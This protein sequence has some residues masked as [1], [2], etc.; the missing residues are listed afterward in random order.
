MKNFKKLLGLCLILISTALL[1]QVNASTS[2][3][4]IDPNKSNTFEF[5]SRSANYVY[6]QINQFFET[7]CSP[8]DSTILLTAI[9][10]NQ[11][12]FS[13]TDNNNTTWEYFVQ[14][15]TGNMPIGSG[16]LINQKTVTITGLTGIVGSTLAPNTTYEFYLRANC[17]Q[18]EKSNW[19]GPIR[20]TTL[21]NE[22]VL[23]FWEG[24]N[25]NSTSL[26]CWTIID[27]NND[28]TSPTGSNIF[29]TVASAY[30]SDQSMYFNGSKKD[31][32]DDWLITPT[33]SIQS[34]KYYKLRYHYKTSSSYK[35]SFK[36]LLSQ[37][38][39]DVQSFVQTLQN[40]PTE[41]DGDWQQETV[42]ISGITAS[43]NIAWHVNT[44]D[45]A[46]NLYIDNVFFEEIP[47]PQP[48]NLASTSPT[49]NG[50]TITWEDPYATQWEFI[51]QN[52]LAGA[53]ATTATGT[54]TTTTSNAITT[55]I[56]G[57]T[58]SSDTE[59]EYYVRSQCSA[60]TYGEWSGPY[61]FRTACDTFNTPFW[62]GFNTESTSINC[63]TMVDVNNDATSPTGNNLWKANTTRYE[64]SHSMM[65]YGMANYKH[66]DWLISPT[67]NLDPTKTYRLK[68]NYRT[69][70]TTTYDFEFAV[71]LSTNGIASDQFNTI[72]VPTQ[73]YAPSVNW[74][75]AYTFISGIGGQIN[76][77][78]HVTSDGGTYI[79]IDNVYVEEV[80]G[81][82]EPIN[83]GAKDEKTDR[84]TIYWDNDNATKWEYYL[85][86]LGAGLP[87]TAGTSTTQ[88]EV[89][90]TTIATGQNLL[91][92]TT[93]EFYVRTDCGNGDSSIWSGPFVFTTACASYTVPFW[94]GFNTNS[95]T[96][97]CWTIIDANAD[98][99]SPT[100]N[101]IWRPY[102]N[103]IPTGV[104]EG[105]QSM[106]FNG[107]ATTTP[108]D[109]W[110]IS[111]ILTLDPGNY[112]L[113]YH[114]RT[115]A[116]F[117]NDFEVLLSENGPDITQFNDTILPLKSYKN[118]NFV[119]EI[120]L[121]NVG[122][123]KE[124]NIAWHA[125][126]KGSTYIY[127]D[128]IAL[129]K[130][131]N[132]LEP[133][134]ITISN[135][136]AT[137]FDISWL[138][139]DNTTEWEVI[140][141]QYG[142]DQNGTII[143]QQTVSNTPSTTINGLPS[144]Q[145]YTVMV[146]AVCKNNNG[147][148]NYSTSANLVT[149]IGNNNDCDGAINLPVN[150]S[151]SCEQIVSSSFYGATNST[152]DEPA[153]SCQPHTLPKKDVWFKFTALSEI[154]LLSITDII[155]FSGQSTPTIYA[156]LYDAQ[157]CIALTPTSSLLCFQF[158]SSIREKLFTNLIVGQQYYLRLAITTTN[159]DAIFNLC[160]TSSE[161]G[162]IEVSP[163]GQKY[164]VDEL[165]KN[166]LISSQC[167]LVSNVKFQ[168][169]DGQNTVNAF[170]YFN[171]QNADFPFEEGI[172]LATGD[173]KHIPGPHIY[174]GLNDNRSKIPVWTG[175]PDLNKII[176]DLGGKSFG[177]NKSVSVLEFD[178]IPINDSISFEYLF[179]SQSYHKDCISYA[180]T[181]GGA[182]FAAW[183]IDLETGEGQNLALL[184]GT[185][186][187]IAL[188][189]IRDTDKSGAACESRN[190]EYYG[191]HYTNGVNS[192]LDAPFNF[193][194]STI[195]MTS[196]KVS[197]NSCKKYKIKLAIADFCPSVG[198]TSAVF[199]NAGS[200]NLGNINLGEDLLIENN[201]AMCPGSTTLLNSKL[202]TGCAD[203]AVINWFKDGA[204][205]QGQNQSTLE[206]NSAGD[207]KV[208][209]ELPDLNCSSIGTIKVEMYPNLKDIIQPAN[210]IYVCRNNLNSYELD[211]SETLNSMFLK[212]KRAK[213]N[214]R[215][216]ETDE[217]AQTE[218]NEI[219]FTD[220]I[221]YKVERTPLDKT[222]Y[223]RIED[224]ITQCFEVFPLKII[225]QTGEFP[226]QKQDVHVCDAYVL[227]D[228]PTNQS[229]HIEVNG[230]IIP[231]AANDIINQP[232]QTEVILRQNN[233]GGCYEQTTFKV[234]I[235]PPITADQFANVTVSCETYSLKPLSANNSYYTKP[236]AKGEELA[237]GTLIT[238]DATIYIYAKTEDGLCYD[239][240]SFTICYEDC[241]IPKGISPNGDGLN[242]N[243]D[244][245]KHNIQNIKI[246]NRWGA[247]VYQKDTVYTNEWHGQ[248]MNNKKLPAT[249]YYYIATANNKIRTGWVEIND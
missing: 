102:P 201:T 91:P 139:D 153:S 172:V 173:V 219:P 6:K 54:S 137:G 31:L 21:C 22:A 59:Y 94:E 160:M 223:I 141:V 234:H 68:Y 167:D 249:T 62:E 199:F 245:T 187:P 217:D 203:N 38:G 157:P 45:S 168:A 12:T 106:Y 80:E 20:F 98:S 44:A 135:I 64:G 247:L 107:T 127:L 42:I 231:Y 241:P 61:I 60:N 143:Q 184:P 174:T 190:K 119:E 58:L 37:Q 225:V 121:F 124:V 226:E 134:Q 93:Y 198:H 76:L 213:Y 84:T 240:S 177:K 39:T 207:Y 222:L 133:Y 165:V 233:G 8:P 248:D 11:A 83:L 150:T 144:G 211:I 14:T 4:A 212:T 237:V 185:N 189:T 56:L 115:S 155:S 130:V 182:L 175:D 193:A 163:S 28:S 128:N 243:F 195:A 10:N 179:A 171:K 151:S 235:T 112:I 77:G 216:F 192:L 100:G 227:P 152:I 161:F 82:P 26:G 246:Y 197:V 125:P 242:D 228:L 170:G 196:N 232:G 188:S 101:N 73:K 25:K 218:N 204:L 48:F 15:A 169:G 30:E 183:L 40:K 41:S 2:S 103:T 147:Y 78:W 142:E 215:Y 200:F 95:T 181:E 33:F 71:K 29:H 186:S 164:T 92:N 205:I 136:T 221:N 145:G 132:C 3:K 88:K 47:C 63:W 23:P 1:Y 129:N 120:I 210:T 17:N 32:H 202:S 230:K 116:S 53:P 214:T 104:Y 140:I 244:L 191:K 180:C 55:D 72:I 66:D 194:G 16:N 9:S 74:Q 176:D 149:T 49:S 138:Q 117:N 79:Y 46:T 118:G 86:L 208:Q 113:K 131:N 166:V 220:I 36:V 156:S 99:T 52:K 51:V 70:S 158:N 90:V 123:K 65:F 50:S 13:W 7:D 19:V 27:N 206:I 87:T 105:D 162:A 34:A 236:N 238:Q 111:P 97:R 81:C 18:N 89:T 69:T 229:Y 57:V 148:S 109:D 114:Y 224:K 75:L 126:S 146:R 96:A 154:Q 122:V 35:N 43:I 5:L 85:Q 159:A 209:I 178:F 239:E 24:F 110:L 67:I 108:N